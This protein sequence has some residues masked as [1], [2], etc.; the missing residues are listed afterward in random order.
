MFDD[1]K[2]EKAY[3]KVD[4]KVVWT[5]TGKNSQLSGPNICGSNTNDPAF[6]V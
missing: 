2:G 1:W 5:K 6:A 3:M 4:D